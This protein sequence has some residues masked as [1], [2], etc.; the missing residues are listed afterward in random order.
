[1]SAPALEKI[2]KC[3]GVFIFMAR[4]WTTDSRFRF[5]VHNRD[6]LSTL[7]SD[8]DTIIK[9]PSWEFGFLGDLLILREAIKIEIFTI[10]PLIMF[11]V[12]RAGKDKP[13]EIS[14]GG[15]HFRE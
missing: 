13:G 6:G 2:S 8:P 12:I 5:D 15:I 14:G 1:M 7:Q 10:K 9:H 11:G 3:R 4:K